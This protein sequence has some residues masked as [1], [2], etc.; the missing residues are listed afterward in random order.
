MTLI[1]GI[2]KKI[3]GKIVQVMAGDFTSS[4]KFTKVLKYTPKVFK[5]KEYA[6]GCSGS[7]RMNQL[8]RYSD[9]PEEGAK[10]ST[11]QTLHN[12]F[13]PWVRQVLKDGG[14]SEINN[15]VEEFN[16]YFLFY[17]GKYIQIVHRNFST[18]RHKNG[19][20][21]VG[22]GEY[23]AK[24]IME[25]YFHMVKDKK[26]EFDLTYLIKNV[27]KVVNETVT[28]V[29]KEHTMIDLTK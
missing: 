5:R 16:G 11:P 21:A 24:A 9:F 29:S 10:W 25:S 15:S 19:I 6:F 18:L 23:H 4:N 28:T 14:L 8:L 27:F 2:D 20:Y 26:V 3:N 17:N 7:I 13:I 22:S 1:I 12:S